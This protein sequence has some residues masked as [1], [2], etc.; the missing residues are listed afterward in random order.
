MSTV[1]YIVYACSSIITFEKLYISFILNPQLGILL[2]LRGI[3][4]WVCVREV[5][6]TQMNFS[7]IALLVRMGV[8]LMAH[9]LQQ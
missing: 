8:W 6:L 5:S 1:V 4:T 2:G 3:V 7:Y 9:V